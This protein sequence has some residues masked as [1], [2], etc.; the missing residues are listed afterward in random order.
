MYCFKNLSLYQCISAGLGIKGK[1][2]IL[3]LYWRRCVN[4]GSYYFNQNYDWLLFIERNKD[5]NERYD[6]LQ[7]GPQ[8][9]IFSQI[10]AK[11]FCH[12]LDFRYDQC[13]YLY[14]AWIKRA[15]VLN[16]NL[17][18]DFLCSTLDIGDLSLLYDVCYY[19][20]D[21][22]RLFSDFYKKC[23]QVHLGFCFYFWKNA[24]MDKE[25]AKKNYQ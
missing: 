20:L 8:S 18:Y 12:P 3:W 16:R 23:V 13:L 25:L 9:T 11:F 2:L 4:S 7:I 6:L 15:L 17:K 24:L 14:K 1:R 5:I 10:N 21:K 22:Q 19:L